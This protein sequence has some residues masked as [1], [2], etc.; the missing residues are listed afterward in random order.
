METILKSALRKFKSE[1]HIKNVLSG[2]WTKLFD[3]HGNEL[4]GIRGRIGVYE[5]KVDGTKIGVDLIEM[6]AGSAFPLHTHDGDHILY[7]LSGNGMVHVDGTDHPMKPGD[8]VFIPAEY[9]HGVKTYS[10]APESFV[11]L[12][13]GHPH[14]KLEALD[15]MKLVT[16]P[17]DN[18]HTH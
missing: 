5:T 8:T 1:K 12:A 9:P 3:E 11:L 14:K 17:E 16:E 4:K 7:G 10:D 18:S 6:S 13:F 15:R 2:A